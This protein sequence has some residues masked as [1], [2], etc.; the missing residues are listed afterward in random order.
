MA[1]E[2]VLNLI[3]CPLSRTYHP[4]LQPKR[5]HNATNEK[6]GHSRELVTVRSSLARG[7]RLS[8]SKHRR[9]KSA[10]SLP[11]DGQSPSSSPRLDALGRQVKALDKHVKRLEKFRINLQPKT[12][13]CQVL[14]T[15]V[16]PTLFVILTIMLWLST[17]RSGSSSGFF[18]F[19]A[20]FM[21]AMTIVVNGLAYRHRRTC[22]CWPM[23][24]AKQAESGEAKS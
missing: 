17:C 7:R 13:P 24:D 10:D 19:I 9:A 3:S 23:K 6:S 14:T 22:R 20:Y 8:E 4:D 15:I 12:H 11:P 21:L 1:K 2:T 5:I 16:H 18:V